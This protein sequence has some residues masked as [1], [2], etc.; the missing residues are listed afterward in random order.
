M[1]PTNKELN[2]AR[3]I[4]ERLKEMG[5]DTLD[6]EKV[7][8]FG[9]WAYKHRSELNAAGLMLSSG[10]T[11]YVFISE[12]ELENWVLKTNRT[13][14]DLCG[15]EAEIYEEAVNEGLGQY[16]APCYKI[17]GAPGWCI[18]ERVDVNEGEIRN[19]IIEGAA[20]HGVDC[21]DGYLDEGEDDDGPDWEALYDYIDD[22]D[23]EDRLSCIYGECDDLWKFMRKKASKNHLNSDLHAGN[24]GV[25][26]ADEVVIIDYSGFGGY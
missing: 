24:F 6:R 5:L 23:D 25:N 18:M 17:E 20:Q 14:D 10:A 15:L 13:A 19:F 8:G 3:G 26:D 2:I 22:L 21:F 7:N 1:H 11:K 4:I 12:Q 9:R 16:F